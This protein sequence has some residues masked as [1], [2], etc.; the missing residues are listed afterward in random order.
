MRK[1]SVWSYFQSVATEA[2]KVVWPSRE[3]VLR[4][5]LMVVVSVAVAVLIFG[6]ADYGLQKLVILAIS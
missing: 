4:H 3:T 2:R 6:G 5:T 1:F